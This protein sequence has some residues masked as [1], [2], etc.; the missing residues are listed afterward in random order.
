M[1]CLQPHDSISSKGE[2]PSTLRASLKIGESVMV[3]MCRMVLQLSQDHP[4][5]F[6]LLP[7][8]LSRGLIKA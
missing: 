2:T 8:Q 4:V 7:V 6:I 5:T 3:V 1:L